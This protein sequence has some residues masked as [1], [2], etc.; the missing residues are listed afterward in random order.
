MK[1]SVFGNP[2]LAFDNLPLKLLPRLRE[3]FPQWEFVFEDPNELD[4]PS[5]DLTEWWVID[6][7]AGL[8]RG[9]AFRGVREVPLEK[10]IAAPRVSAHDFD[11]GSYLALIHKIRPELSVRI[12]GVPMGY[13]EENAFDELVALLSHCLL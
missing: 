9:E 2:D 13:D 10:L 11:L 1:I 6:T 8:P 7:V 3:R 4:L 12:F 5:E